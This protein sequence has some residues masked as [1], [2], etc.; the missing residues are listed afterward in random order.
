[1]PAP[2]KFCGGSSSRIPHRFATFVAGALAATTTASFE[3]AEAAMVFTDLDLYLDPET[4]PSAG[5]IDLNGDGVA[6]IGL[7]VDQGSSPDSAGNMGLALVGG[8]NGASI[9]F[10][11]NYPTAFQEGSLISSSLSFQKGIGA[12]AVS[13]GGP[14]GSQ[15]EWLRGNDAY[16]GAR[17]EVAGEYFFGWLH[18][19]W[20][21]EANALTIDQVAFDD[22]GSAALIS[23]P[24]V[25]VAE[26]PENFQLEVGSIYDPEHG[27]IEWT[28]PVLANKTYELQRSTNLLDWKT[29]HAVTPIADGQARFLDDELTYAP[30]TRCFYRVKQSDQEASASLLLLAL[31]LRR[32]RDEKN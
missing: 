3:S 21:P 15:G 13:S 30:P 9:A 28:W 25:P 2:Q 12:I 16:L 23:S 10:S 22:S 20:N 1:M 18:A 32:R 31:G 8:L 26:E 5:R 7:V 24:P 17:F 14:L 27:R 29:I 4:D 19:V 11:G 6:D